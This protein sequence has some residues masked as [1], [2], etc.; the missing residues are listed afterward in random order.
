MCIVIARQRVAKH[1]LAA[2]YTQ[3]TIEELPL[4]CN[5]NVNTPP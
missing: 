5:D 4:L 1:I 3:A 2:T